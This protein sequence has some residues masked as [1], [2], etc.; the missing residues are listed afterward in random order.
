MLS[1]TE[2]KTLYLIP[3]GEDVDDSAIYAAQ[4]R[5]KLQQL[6]S[7]IRIEGPLQLDLLKNDLRSRDKIIIVSGAGISINAGGKSHFINAI[8]ATLP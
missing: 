3:A 8:W 1:L 7:K 2:K 5:K 4:P 6:E